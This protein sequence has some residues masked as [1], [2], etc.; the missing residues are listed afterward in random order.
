MVSFRSASTQL[1]SGLIGNP[2]VLLGTWQSDGSI[3]VHAFTNA[4]GAVNA[5]LASHYTS[6]KAEVKAKREEV[7]A[8]NDSTKAADA[9]AVAVEQA[10]AA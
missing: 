1:D 10:V 6:M 8:A 5:A 9:V 3:A 4:V 7:V 2:V